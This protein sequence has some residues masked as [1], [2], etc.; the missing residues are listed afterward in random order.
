MMRFKLLG[1]GLANHTFD[2]LYAVTPAPVK[3]QEMSINRR[4][5]Q[6]SVLLR[7]RLLAA[8]I[9]SLLAL[10]LWD[11][12]PYMPGSHTS[13]LRAGCSLCCL[14]HRLG[15]H[16]RIREEAVAAPRAPHT[17]GESLSETCGEPQSASH[18][19]SV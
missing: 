9:G 8:P 18:L 4:C 12:V 19:A 3:R 15:G 2:V 10:W 7:L 6:F 16:R 1:L 17:T 11:G 5:L 13:R 14:H